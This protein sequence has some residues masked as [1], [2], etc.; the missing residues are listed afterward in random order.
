MQKIFFNQSKKI[1]LLWLLLYCLTLIISVNWL[2]Q[3]NYQQLQTQNQQQ[4]D[5]FSR[6]LESQ[7]GHYAYIPQLLSHQ[8]IVIKALQSS[9]NSAQLELT[10]RH[11]ASVNNIIGAADTYLLDASGTTISASNWSS[12]STFIGNNFAFRPYFQD[13]KIGLQG[14]YFALGFASGKRGYYFSYPVVYAAEV[15][16]VIVVKMDLSSIE[17]D[18]TGKEQLFLV[19]DANNIVFIS[20]EKKWLFQSLSPLSDT[21]KE[22][23]RKSR[24]YL[25]Q[26][27]DSLHISG[28]LHE[29]AT[30][31]K[32]KSKHSVSKHYLSLINASNNEGWKIRVFAPITSIIFNITMLILFITLLFVVMYL[33]VVLFKQKQSRHD[34]KVLAEIKS[35]QQLE[36]TVMKRTSALQAEIG[37]RHKAETALRSTQKELIQSAKLAVLGQLSASISHELNNPLAAIR[38]YAENAVLF[39]QRDKLEQ[40]ESNLT[41]IVLLTERMAKISSQLK[42]FARKSNGELQV[43]SLQ[44]IILA[45]NELLKP[46]F[47]ASQVTLQMTLPEQ[48][49]NVKAEAIQLEQIIVNLLSNAMQ[50]MQKSEQKLIEIKLLIENDLAVIKVL[51][52][53]T[54]IDKQHLPHLFDPFFTTK[55]TGLGLGLSIS[56]QIISNMQGKLCAKNREHQGAEFCITLPLFTPSTLDDN[57]VKENL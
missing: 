36:F 33:I 4:L 20:S 37:E 28:D 25:N 3:Y 30:L 52:K 40:V 13:A 55:D 7:L 23:I 54:G 56:Q 39:L 57:T 17:K 9:D 42:S 8:E 29:N 19:T 43:I 53:G 12:K 48:V 21:Q 50:A 38:S 18:W 27:I 24:R 51:D 46:Q 31:L 16:G 34:E 35:K 44:P 11:L 2:W 41:R 15:I 10:N 6:H 45:A 47:K 22:N 26:Q 32:F 1:R 49:I 14:R 5:R